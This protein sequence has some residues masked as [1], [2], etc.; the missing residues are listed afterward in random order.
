MNAG[1]FLKT[2][3]A[4]MLSVAATY[5]LS[6]AFYTQQ[7]I[8]KMAAVGAE[9]STQQQIDTFFDNFTGLWILGAM[10][11]IALLIGF[12][13]AFFVKRVL[14]PLAF[15][16]YPAA[17]AVAMLTM[18][19]LIEQQLGGGAGIV[20][21]ARDATGLALQA[22]AGLIGGGVFAGLRPR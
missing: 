8:A 18:L 3:V 14:K 13:V 21:G 10:I 12:T 20:G 16:A 22:L 19:V 6:T 7:V 9:Y 2:L 4:Y 5:V 15:V 1:A 17:G 11:A